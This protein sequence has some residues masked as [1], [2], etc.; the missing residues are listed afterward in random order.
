MGNLD[1]M[2]QQKK[3]FKSQ[4]PEN[5]ENRIQPKKIEEKK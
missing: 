3:E 5:H 4:K 2:Q 1:A